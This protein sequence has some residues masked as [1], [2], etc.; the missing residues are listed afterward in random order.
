MVYDPW[1]KYIGIEIGRVYTWVHIIFHGHAPHKALRQMY[2]DKRA[3][4]PYNFGC[5]GQLQTEKNGNPI[6][7]KISSIS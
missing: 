2:D 6:S 4:V 7:L 5:I 3:F 1:R